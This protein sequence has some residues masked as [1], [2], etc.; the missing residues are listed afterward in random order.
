MKKI[1]ILFVFG[2]VAVAAAAQEPSTEPLSAIREA[3]A[4][5]EYS[6]SISLIDSAL[7]RRDTADAEALRSLSLMKAR[8][9]KRLY[10]YGDACR[11][12]EAVAD[13]ADVEVLG[14]L[15]DAYASDGETEKALD[16]YYWLMMKQPDNIYFRLQNLSLL[17]RKKDW[18]QCVFE[19]KVALGIDSLPQ[20]LSAVGHAYSKVGQVD[21]SLVYYDKALKMRPDN[22]GYLTSVCNLLLS[23]EE[24]G[25]AVARTGRYLVNINADEPEVEAIYG[26]ASYQLRSYGQAYEAFR[27]LRMDGDQSYATYYYGGL[28]AAV[29]EK[30]DEA[31]E[32][33]ETAWQI[34][35][36]D[37][38]LAAHYGDALRTRYR[39]G[40]AMKMYEN[41]TELMKPNPSVEY[42]VAFGMGF[43]KFALEKYKEAIPYYKRAYELNP[44]QISALSSI[45]YCYE[46]Q[47]DFAEAKKW[48]EKYLAV[49]KPGSRAYEFVEKSLEY[50]N[51]ELF[52]E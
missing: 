16:V 22:V 46:R 45:G 47:K 26:F 50:V 48:Y 49:G 42:K 11:T 33:F 18:G 3:M 17:G 4:K 8:C 5:Y 28:S 24:Y 43:S 34:D 14:E 51:G 52:M 21:S 31:L 12:L 19:G 39:Y 36:T 27:K 7:V 30:V 25:E 1:L 29:L 2:F 44:K 32:C 9:Q 35:S 23:R 10:K 40:E 37:S 15:A 20:I 13:S 41:A 6:Y 38:M